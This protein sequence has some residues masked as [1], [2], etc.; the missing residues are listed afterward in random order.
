MLAD[1]ITPLTAITFAISALRQTGLQQS[2]ISTAW[3]DAT[4]L[5]TG[6]ESGRGGSVA[7]FCGYS[8][9]MTVG[10]KFH[11]TILRPL[12]ARHAM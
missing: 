3:G 5:S 2:R 12:V 9:P 4:A 1:H 11:A 7:T 8:S 10:K 6:R